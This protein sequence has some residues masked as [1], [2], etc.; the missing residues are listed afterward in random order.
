MI[1]CWLGVVVDRDETRDKV[2]YLEQP[3]QP[4]EQGRRRLLFAGGQSGKASQKQ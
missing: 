3:R 4:I 2:D 1:V